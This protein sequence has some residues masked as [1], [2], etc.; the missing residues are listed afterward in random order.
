MVSPVWSAAR[1]VLAV[2]AGYVAMG[3]LITLVQETWLGGVSFTHSPWSLLLVAGFFT[4]LSAV[5][6]GCLA[7]WICSHHPVRHGLVMSAVVVGETTWLITTGRTY[8][9]VWFDMAAGASLIA[10][11]QLGTLLRPAAKQVAT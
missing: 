1:S 9:P 3:L 4:F 2:V 11:I 8:D 5:A 10:G 7:A 6:G